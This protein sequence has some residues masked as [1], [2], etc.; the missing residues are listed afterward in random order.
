MMYKF[1]IFFFLLLNF[2][3]GFGNIEALKI[4]EEVSFIEK[5]FE[6]AN[7]RP[8]TIY[9]HPENC[10]VF[11]FGYNKPFSLPQ[12][13]VTKND[14]YQNLNIGTFLSYFFYLR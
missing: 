2:L 3:I 13:V 7:Q 5:A 10:Y 9:F 4:K 12:I 11:N 8:H 6:W 14:V 1:R